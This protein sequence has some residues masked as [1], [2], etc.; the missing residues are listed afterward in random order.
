MHI[1]ATTNSIAELA[2]YVNRGNMADFNQF[3]H[4][5]EKEFK[6]EIISSDLD[7]YEGF[8]IHFIDGGTLDV[9]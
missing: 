9:S 1:Q 5:I 8:S 6:Q 4:N 7:Y 3:F 2:Q